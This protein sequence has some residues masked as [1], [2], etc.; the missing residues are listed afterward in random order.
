MT[1]SV[2]LLL[3]GYEAVRARL[4][5]LVYDLQLPLLRLEQEEVVPDLLHLG[6]QHSVSTSW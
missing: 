3:R 4:L 2:C 6:S 1:G 5:A